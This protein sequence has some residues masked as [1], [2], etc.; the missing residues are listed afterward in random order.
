MFANLGVAAA[1]PPVLR[2]TRTGSMPVR[3]K[4]ATRYAQSNSLPPP[5]IFSL[6]FCC[7]FPFFSQARLL[8][9]TLVKFPLHRPNLT[10]PSPHFAGSL[11]LQLFALFFNSIF[12]SSDEGNTTS[13]ASKSRPQKICFRSLTP[14]F[15]IFY[16]PGL[17]EVKL[18]S[19]L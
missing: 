4:V 9:A 17:A 14:I 3:W 13:A 5:H 6:V 16:L 18:Y 10:P 7:F 1:P 15:C 2:L 12:H 19:M 11:L 8:I